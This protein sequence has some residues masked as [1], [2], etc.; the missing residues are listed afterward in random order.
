MACRSVGPSTPSLV[1]LCLPA[2]RLCQPSLL[3]PWPADP[4]PPRSSSW[5]CRARRPRSRPPPGPGSRGPRTVRSRGAVRAQAVRRRGH[6]NPATVCCPALPLPAPPRSVFVGTLARIQAHVH[7]IA[8]L[9]AL[10][11]LAPYPY[12]PYTARHCPT[13]ASCP[14]FPPG[15]SLSCPC[16]S[17]PLLQASW[18]T[19]SARMY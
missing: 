4:W 7:M 16:P 6:D 13:S 5:C 9:A 10:P 2:P 8:W 19:C 11:P 18:C 14:P 15:T 17:P 3:A 12:S 1:V